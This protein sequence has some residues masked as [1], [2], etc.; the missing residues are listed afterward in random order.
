MST[1]PVTTAAA[2]PLVPGERA[3]LVPKTLGPPRESWS[4]PAVTV[5][6]VLLSTITVTLADGSEVTTNKANVVRRRPPDPPPR[7]PRPRPAPV[8]PPGVEQL[9]IW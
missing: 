7:V 3:Y 2:A 8:L 9:E 1:R 5:T 6:R 4:K